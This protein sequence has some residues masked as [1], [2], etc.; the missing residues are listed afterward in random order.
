MS[1]NHSLVKFRPVITL[2]QITHIINLT[3]TD[4][5]MTGQNIEANKDIRKILVPMVAKIEVGAIS[6]AYKLSE[7]QII[8]S[9]EK[10]ERERYENGLMSSEEEMIYESKILGV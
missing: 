4:D 10:N 5:Q 9:Q 6:P 8:K 1:V 3:H 2:A 7:I